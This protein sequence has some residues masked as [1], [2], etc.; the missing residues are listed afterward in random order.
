MRRVTVCRENRKN[1]QGDSQPDR[2]AQFAHISTQMATALG[3]QQRVISI[4][5]KKKAHSSK[6]SATTA[7]SIAR[8]ARRKRSGC[9]IC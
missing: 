9:T 8:K 1:Q 7:A 3:E 6:T 5:T 4:D 2:D